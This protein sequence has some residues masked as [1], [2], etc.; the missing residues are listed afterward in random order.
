MENCDFKTAARKLGLESY[1]PSL[2]DITRR[3]EAKRIVWWA[4]ETSNKLRD[5][6]LEIGDQIHVF[7]IARKE[8][9]ADHQPNAKHEASL[10]RQWGI[11]CD[12]DDDLND[13]KTAIELWEQRENINRLVESLA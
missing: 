12:L 2:Q 5:V 7:S 1:R 4:R 6:L 9:G 8:S 11:L 3:K 13:P 10:I